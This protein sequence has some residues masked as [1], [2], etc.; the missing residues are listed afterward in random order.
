[1]N[2][3]KREKGQ[4]DS[5]G[6]IFAGLLLLFFLFLNP[7]EGFEMDILD[8]GQGDGSFIKTADGFTVFVDGGSSDVKK[9]GEYRI[10]PFLKSKGIK[11]V[12]YWFVSHTDKDHI[13]GLKEILELG[14]PIR[15]LVFSKEM[16][17]DEAYMELA[18]LAH[19]QGT[20]I[21]SLKAGDTLHLSD[22]AIRAVFPDS[23][24]EDKNAGSLVLLYEEGEFSGI[25]TG[26]IGIAEEKKILALCNT[27]HV[28]FYKAA[29]HGSKKSNSAEFLSH[30]SPT[31]SAVSCGLKNS[32]GHP[33]KEA[34]EHMEEAGS[35]VFYTMYGGQVKLT[36]QQETIVVQKYTQPLDVFCFP[37]VE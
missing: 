16:N 13:S 34:V 19:K 26:D 1:M 29:H 21:L 23:A 27:G 28:D 20:K 18:A 32:Y 11:N 37:V 25:F 17:P 5:L 14:Y 4:A 35:T 9:V 30:L 7:Q 8:V 2:K 31:V 15:Y 12:D 36:L 10:L 22:A 24:Q 3:T 33:G 6:H